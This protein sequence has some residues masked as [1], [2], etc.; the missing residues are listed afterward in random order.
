ME[1]RVRLSQLP[2]RHCRARCCRHSLLGDGTG[3]GR[4]AGRIWLW[5]L[6]SAPHLG[7]YLGTSHVWA[8][9]FGAG[10]GGARRRP[11]APGLRTFVKVSDGRALHGKRRLTKPPDNGIVW[12]AVVGR[13]GGCRSTELLRHQGPRWRIN[14]GISRGS[15]SGPLLVREKDGLVPQSRHGMGV[16]HVHRVLYVSVLRNSYFVHTYI[17]VRAC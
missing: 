9:G 8:P 1:R 16:F 15:Y 6:P 11:L 14:D 7:L 13:Y 2:H 17:R 4:E 12:L 10:R 5:Q 3:E